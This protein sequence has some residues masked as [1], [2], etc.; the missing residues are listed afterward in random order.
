MKVTLF[1]MVMYVKSEHPSKALSPMEV[2][3][4]PMATYIKL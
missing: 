4:F 3:P 1:G 2:T